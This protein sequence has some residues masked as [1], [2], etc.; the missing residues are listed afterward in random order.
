MLEVLISFCNCDGERDSLEEAEAASV[1]LEEGE[2]EGVSNSGLK[3]LEADS[4]AEVE[5]EGA[6][7]SLM[8]RELSAV[9]DIDQ[10]SLFEGEAAKDREGVSLGEGVFESEL[11]E[12]GDAPMLKLSVTERDTDSAAEEDGEGVSLG[13]GV[14]E[15]ELVEE[16]DAPM[17]KLS[18]TERDSDCVTL[19]DRETDSEAEE[20]GEEVTLGE[21][22]FESELVEE[23]DAP[24]L[25]LSV[26]ESDSD[27]VALED[28]V[29]DGDSETDREGEGEAEVL[30]VAVIE[31]LTEGLELLGGRDSRSTEKSP[32]PM[33]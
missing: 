18:V 16:G 24:M 15:S 13:E 32:W 22:V 29:D 14:F 2:A 33:S 8:E 6:K 26:T 17:L 31:G 10:V 11:V 21:G 25:K 12:L 3:V 9:T 30:K 23:G 1:G 4:T 28:E 19:E 20:D 27:S 5:L 7:V